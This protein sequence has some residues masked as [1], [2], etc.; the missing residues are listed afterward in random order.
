MAELGW[1][2]G[3]IQAAIEAKGQLQQQQQSADLFALVKEDDQNKVQEGQLK[4]QQA[5]L[6]L[7][8]QQK[9]MTALAATGTNGQQGGVDQMA[10]QL[11]SYATA[12][13]PFAPEE[14]KE[15]STAASG[16]LKNQSEIADKALAHQT[17]VSDDYAKYLGS[18]KS[19]EEFDQGKMMFLME[20]GQDQA[21]AKDPG[22]QQ[23]LQQPY[24]PKLVAAIHAGSQTALQQAQQKASEARTKASQGELA[25]QK[26]EIARNEAIAAF[27]NQLVANRKKVGAGNLAPKASDVKLITD[28]MKTAYGD[29]TDD[30]QSA[31]FNTRALRAAEDMKARVARGEPLSSAA[32][33]AFE[34]RRRQGDF[35][36]LATRGKIG[37]PSDWTAPKDL[38]VSADKLQ[39]NQIYS[40]K[41]VPKIYDKTTRRLY[42]VDEWEQLSG[43]A[44]DAEE[45]GDPDDEP[46]EDK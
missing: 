42:T 25:V 23:L 1:G 38:P 28:Q 44:Y 8:R 31:D 32:K 21:L 15:Y 34:Y 17:K 29:P 45:G 4:I 37:K 36:G 33:A 10:G 26:S 40:V 20:H 24:S 2:A 39:D 35:A 9:M 27:D 43:G 19:K 5:R 12:V 16:L 30:S 3:G 7:E 11:L 14:A 41:G 18:A 46:A 22:F 6:D 13:A